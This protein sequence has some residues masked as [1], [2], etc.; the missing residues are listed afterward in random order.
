M[1][2]RTAAVSDA[3]ALTALINRA[4]EVEKFFIDTERIAM[5]QIL[6][7][8]DAG[9]FLTAGENGTIDACVY[10]EVRGSRGYFGLLSVDPSRQRLGL[11]RLLIRAAEEHCRAAG[12]RLMDLQIVNLREELP[13][14]YRK[15]GYVETGTAP[16]PPDVQ[17]KLPCHF[18]KMSKPLCGAY[19]PV[20]LRFDLRGD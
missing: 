15:L 9:T 13:A 5:P 1:S 4:F 17:T 16:F 12:C 3:E 6:R 10:V 2:I 8:L 7:F 11:G 18:V 20:G 14:F 19:L